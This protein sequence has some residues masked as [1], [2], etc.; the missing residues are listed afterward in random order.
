MPSPRVQ[1]IC[2]PIRESDP[3]RMEAAIQRAKE[4]AQYLELRLDYLDSSVLT[5]QNL[6]KWANL[7]DLPVI[8]TFRRK[9]N[10]GEFPGSDAQQ[11]AVVHAIIEAEFPF[12]DLEIETIEGFLHGDLDPLKERRTQIIASYHNFYETPAEVEEI[13]HRLFRVQP[14]VLKIA[15]L[16]RSFSDNF[17]LLNLIPLAKQRG[18]PIIP[19]AMGELGL[20]SRIL[21]PSCGALLTYASLEEGKETAPGQ[22]TA[23]DLADIYAIQE[24]DNNTRVMGV[25]GYPLGHSL[26]P[27]IHNRAFRDRQLNCRY[28]P[29]P[30]K[31]LED[32]A[33]HLRDFSGFSVTIPHKLAIRKYADELDET[34]RATG[35]A[36]TLVWE[37]HTLRA[38][39]TDV[40]GIRQALYEPL[41][42]GIGKTVLLGA[43]GAARAAAVVLRQSGCQ[44][45]VL[46]RDL[47]K[48]AKFAQEFGFS[49]DHLDNCA[50]HPGDLLI[51]ATSVGMTP[52]EN[53]TPVKEEAL[54]YRYVF[55]MVYNPLQTRLL[56]EAQKTARVISGLEMFLAQAA[57]QFE[58]WT[59]VEAPLELMR[60]VVIERLTRS[61]L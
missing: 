33:P 19:V 28:L 3:P 6:R 35:A 40:D 46:A 58:L 26:S 53:Q 48:G 52:H 45:T 30:L 14:D 42:A 18:L 43:G 27:L 25:I 54:N 41:E 1:K 24:I 29:F 5:V 9:A 7:A 47:S 17:R 61:L 55:D 13:S 59:G 11:M 49:W 15:T 23:D 57:R 16:A 39:N 60:Q 32:F 44:V 34:V 21:A 50:N 56:S 38:Y 4:R 22:L 10:G 2:I 37:G 36:N 31:D 51:N 8:G 12:C 20:Y